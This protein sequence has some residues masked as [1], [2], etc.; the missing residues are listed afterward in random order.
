MPF[1]VDMYIRST[2]I[3][4]TPCVFCDVILGAASVF[5]YGD[6][7]HPTTAGVH[8]KGLK[9]GRRRGA[10][11]LPASLVTMDPLRPRRNEVNGHQ[12]RP[13]LTFLSALRPDVST[14]VSPDLLALQEKLGQLYQLLNGSNCAR[15]F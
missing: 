5:P 9:Y 3:H 7:C 13:A 4:S 2:D 1:R 11:I 6:G 15:E 8:H 12:H 10:L 14:V